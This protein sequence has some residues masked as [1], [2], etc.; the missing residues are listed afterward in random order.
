LP[1]C[2]IRGRGYTN[3]DDAAD[4]NMLPEKGQNLGALLCD[5][6]REF[7]YEYD[8]GDGWEHRIVVEATGEPVADWPYPLW[9]W[10]TSSAR[11]RSFS[12]VKKA[13]QRCRMSSGAKALL[14][15][16]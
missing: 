2:H 11:S 13:K 16:A 15:P 12:S 5:S 7:G 4:L 14:P 3:A 10:Q 8:V 1:T 9:R 6:I